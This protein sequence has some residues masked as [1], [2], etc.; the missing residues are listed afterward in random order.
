M[1]LNHF[2]REE[3]MKD[4]RNNKRN[5]NQRYID[6][7]PDKYGNSFN[8]VNKIKK[9]KFIHE[10]TKGRYGNSI[11]DELT[12][13]PMLKVHKLKSR[14]REKLKKYLYHG[15]QKDNYA[16]NKYNLQKGT[17]SSIQ[18]TP[19]YNF[20]RVLDPERERY[21]EEII[22]QIN[23]NNAQRQSVRKIER[24]TNMKNSE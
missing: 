9:E 22:N 5:T 21:N 20:R 11:V 18:L 24:D 6:M 7:N 12:D 2:D 14:R 19:D 17:A 1:W 15:R 23:Q 13:D 10:T 3:R 4:D 8:D 16:Q